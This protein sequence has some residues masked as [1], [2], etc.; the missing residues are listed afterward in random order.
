MIPEFERMIFDLNDG[1][2]HTGILPADHY[3]G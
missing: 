1:L 2:H 3:I